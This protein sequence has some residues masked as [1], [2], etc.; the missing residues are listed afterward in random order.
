MENVCPENSLVINVF[1]GFYV[2]PSVNRKQLFIPATRDK[3]FT[4]VYNMHCHFQAYIWYNI[5]Y[6]VGV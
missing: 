3:L 4:L 5:L 6:N 1:V 2:C